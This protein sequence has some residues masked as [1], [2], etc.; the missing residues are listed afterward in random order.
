VMLT[1]AYFRSG[2]IPLFVILSMV[3]FWLYSVS[4]LLYV[5]FLHDIYEVRLKG[6]LFRGKSY[7]P[8]KEVTS[9]FWETRR[10]NVEG[11][12]IR[13]RAPRLFS[14]IPPIYIPV[15]PEDRERVWAILEQQ[16]A[17]WPD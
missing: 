15:R 5:Y 3:F 14:W 10:A 8:W 2:T 17:E 6:I 12:R 13:I 11:L 16:L 4:F 7:I 1:A 9:Y